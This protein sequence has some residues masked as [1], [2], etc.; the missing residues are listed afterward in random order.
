VQRIN[1]L[2][3]TLNCILT[4]FLPV[5]KTEQ[6]IINKI[7]GEENILAFIKFYIKIFTNIK[8]ITYVVLFR[9]M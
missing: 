2:S 1:S 7:N 8:A 4:I 6:D 5:T 9:R 3:P